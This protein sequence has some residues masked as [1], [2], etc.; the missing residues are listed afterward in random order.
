MYVPVKKIVVHHTAG[1]NDFKDIED[2]KAEI[3]ADYAYHATTLDWGDIGYNML[4]HRWRD[5]CEGRHGRGHGLTREACSPGFVAA[6]ALDH[7]NG[8][9]GIAL[10]ATFTK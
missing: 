2:V 3:R 6:R 9:A 5:V 8:A 4:I 7:I 10:L 1:T